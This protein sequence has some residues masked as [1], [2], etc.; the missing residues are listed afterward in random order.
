[1]ST[2]ITAVNGDLSHLDGGLSLSG[3]LQAQ[4]L[5]AM[6]GIQFP[7]GTVQNTKAATQAEIVDTITS[8]MASNGGNSSAGGGIF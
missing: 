2:L 7:D 4:T 5:V 6:N 8:M 3:N 1:M